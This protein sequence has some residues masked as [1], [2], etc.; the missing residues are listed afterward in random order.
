MSSTQRY[1]EKANETSCTDSE[2]AW[3]LAL[4][5]SERLHAAINNDERLEMSV[6]YQDNWN[7]GKSTTLV[8]RRKTA[9]YE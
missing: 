3:M 2:R 7:A 6:R 4:C 8:D 5:V 1:C 9:H